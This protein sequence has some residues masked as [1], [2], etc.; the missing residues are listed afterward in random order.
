MPVREVRATRGKWL[1]AEPIAALYARGLVSRTAGP[2]PLEDEMCAFGARWPGRR[3]LARPGRRAGLGAD[4]TV[5]RAA[6]S[7]EGRRP[8]LLRGDRTGHPPVDD[9]SLDAS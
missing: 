7:A 2:R 8:R 1:R 9:H 3:P 6:R 5:R 4:R